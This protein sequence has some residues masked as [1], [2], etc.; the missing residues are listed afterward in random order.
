MCSA[1]EFFR[2]IT[3]G[4]N[5]DLLAVLLSEE[6]HRAGLLR[7]IEG[8]D[9]RSDGDLLTDLLVDKILYLPDFFLRHRFEMREVEAQAVRR[10]I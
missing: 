3:H 4:D 7:L 2:E 6:G 1:A 10:D 9:I 8:H 5:A